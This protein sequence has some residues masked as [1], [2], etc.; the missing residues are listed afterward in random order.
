MKRLRTA[1]E[2]VKA[3][4]EEEVRRLTFASKQQLWNWEV[5]YGAFPPRTY[6][7]M[8]RELAKKG[9]TAPPRLWKMLGTLGG[10]RAA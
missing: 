4:G 9:L 6:W 2:V 10:K 1:R 3:L 8:T 7:I 5:Y